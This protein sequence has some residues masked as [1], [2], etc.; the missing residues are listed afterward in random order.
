MNRE[1]EVC[2]E[3]N[4]KTVYMADEILKRMGH[5][6]RPGDTVQYI[7]GN[8]LNLQRENLRILRVDRN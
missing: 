5:I 1:G 7:D 4:G 3:E 2:R 6:L 8:K